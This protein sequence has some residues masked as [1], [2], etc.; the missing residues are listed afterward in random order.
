M[1]A[2]FGTNADTGMSS[3]KFNSTGRTVEFTPKE[4]DDFAEF[5]QGI[6]MQGKLAKS[7]IGHQAIDCLVELGAAIEEGDPETIAQCWCGDGQSI[8]EKAIA[9]N[10]IIKEARENPF[11]L[12]YIG[13]SRRVDYELENIKKALEAS[14][15]IEEIIQQLADTIKPI[16]T[17]YLDREA[18]VISHEVT[19]LIVKAGNEIRGFR[20]YGV[21]VGDTATD[22]AIVD[23]FKHKAAVSWCMKAAED[24]ASEL[25]S[26]I[27]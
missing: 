16:E 11:Q 24:L 15:S 2:T 19:E 26:E 14:K 4:S 25:Y 10:I 23:K 13:E 27:H 6:K 9:N 3:L 1:S 5:L 20:D 21:G 18:G 12:F 22:E 7:D 17:V 8:V